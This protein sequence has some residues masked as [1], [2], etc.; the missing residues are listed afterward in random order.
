MQKFK[1]YVLTEIYAVNFDSLPT[2]NKHKDK[3]ESNVTQLQAYVVS[4]W[5]VGLKEF[6]QVVDL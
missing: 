6:P 3:W 4:A 1:H 5:L 2:Y